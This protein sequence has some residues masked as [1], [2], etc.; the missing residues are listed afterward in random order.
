MVPGAT[1]HCRRTT[2]IV[3]SDCCA[4]MEPATEAPRT[5]GAF[6]A[7]I[8][9]AGQSSWLDADSASWHLDAV[10]PPTHPAAR[11]TPLYTLFSTLLN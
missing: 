2:V 6:F 11:G 10:H 5:T 8:A 7:R 3:A 9:A 4:E 1:D